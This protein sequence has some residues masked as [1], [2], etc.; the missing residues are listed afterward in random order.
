M[1]KNVALMCIASVS[2]VS[3]VVWL[4]AWDSARAFM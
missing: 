1:I 3:C 4:V 2:L